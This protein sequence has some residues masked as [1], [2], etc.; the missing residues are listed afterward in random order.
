MRAARR[1]AMRPDPVC[2]N[3]VDQRVDAADEEAGDRGDVDDGLARRDPAFKG[4]QVGFGHLLVILD[5]EE[6]GDVDVDAPLQ[7]FLDGRR[8]FGGAGNLDHQV[9][10]IYQPCQT[11]GLGDRTGGIPGQQ[12]RY[13]QA[14][15]AV[16]PVSVA[17]YGQQRIAGVAYVLAGEFLVDLQCRPAAAGAACD[18]HVVGRAAAD[19]LA[20][21]GRVGR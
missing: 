9:R 2:E 17:I 5:A 18:L 6:Q 20:E 13:F 4:G 19:C 1:T 7:Q 16:D 3:L 12:R 11:Q 15:V 14:H 10:A 8:T 21:D